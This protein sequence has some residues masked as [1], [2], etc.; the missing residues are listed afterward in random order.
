MYRKEDIIKIEANLDKIKND[1]AIEYKTV[2]EPTL[3][4]SSKVYKAIKDYIKKN[5][6]IVYG[7]FAQNLLVGAKNKSDVFYKEIDEAYFNWPDIADIE[8]YTP[9]PIADVITLTEEL[10]SQGFKYVEGAEG[11]HS[12]T[13]KIFVNFENYCD[14]SYIPVHIYNN[15]PV[16]DV[17]GIKCVHPHFM[18]VDAYRVLT[19][20]MTSYWRIDKSINRFQTILKYYPI[21]Q[22]NADKELFIKKS[23]NED[24]LKFIRKKI[25]HMSKFIAVGLYAYNYYAKKVSDKFIINVPYY[26]LIT[27]ELEKDARPVSYTHLRA[28]ETG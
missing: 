28:H 2:Y 19:D 22:K 25:I 24:V 17:D 27:T 5:K 23:E 18:M 12:E 8:F 9:T 15:L 13:Y 26:E 4:E 6:K 16:I 20:P 3:I 14:I 1:A 11:I 7:G 21:D 10:H